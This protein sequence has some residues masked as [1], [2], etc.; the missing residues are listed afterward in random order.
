MLVG[1][2]GESPCSG[3]Y[4]S[5]VGCFIE[6]DDE[7]DA[8]AVAERTPEAIEAAALARHRRRRA[9]GLPCGTPVDLLPDHIRAV[10]TEV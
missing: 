3:C 5:V 2:E 4:M 1:T 10:L 7:P 8:L 6:G 9:A